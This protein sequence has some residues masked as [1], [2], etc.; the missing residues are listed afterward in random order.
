V[1]HLLN[2][3]FYLLLALICSLHVVTTRYYYTGSKI[4]LISMSEDEADDEL[5]REEIK[6]ET[7][8]LQDREAE[9]E[10]DDGL[11]DET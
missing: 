4:Y 6:E 9:E 11:D 8:E 10:S 7:H 5:K 2:H 3:E 1:Q